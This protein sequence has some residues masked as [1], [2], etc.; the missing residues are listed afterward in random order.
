M[1]LDYEGVKRVLSDPATFSSRVPSPRNW[2]LFSDPPHHTKQRHLIAKAFTP[3]VVANLEP[4]IRELSRR[5]LDDASGRGEMD[6][7]GDYAV[8]LPMKVIAEMIGVPAED[9]AKFRRRR[10]GPG[11]A[12]LRH[13]DRRD[14]PGPGRDDR[15]AAGR[16]EG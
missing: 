10:G 2:F 12:K 7:A 6:L 15:V 13:G 14:G 16:A 8:P 11:D 3:R 1:V 5:L 4:H 9:W